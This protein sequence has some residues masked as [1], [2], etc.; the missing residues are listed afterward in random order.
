MESSVTEVFDDAPR[1]E[2]IDSIESLY[3]TFGGYLA[4]AEM[5]ACPDCVFENDIALIILKP[6][7]QLEV[8]D[9]SKFAFKAISTFGDVRTFKHF[10]P[11]ILELIASGQHFSTNTEITIGKLSYGKWREWPRAEQVAVERFM[12]SWWH[13]VLLSDPD[14]MNVLTCLCCLARTFDD[15]TPFLRK[16]EALC[17]HSDAATNQLATYYME[18]CTLIRDGRLGAFWDESPA[19]EA[20][21]L[22]WFRQ[23]EHIALAA[24]AMNTPAFD[25]HS[26]KWLAI[27]LATSRQ[28]ASASVLED[29]DDT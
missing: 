4:D 10:L 21:A 22:A 12:H 26:R 19:Q 7:R 24:K 8:H 25:E 29:E 20:Q 3:S 14:K 11:R 27:A 13:C 1:Q 2:L 6:L 16:W 18:V 23:P 28:R 15:L 5:P 17:P 9:L